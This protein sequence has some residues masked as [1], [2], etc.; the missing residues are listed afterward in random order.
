MKRTRDVCGPHV[1][2]NARI[3][4]VLMKNGTPEE[5][6]AEVRSLIDAGAP[7]ENFF[8][9]Y[10]GLDYGTPDEN[11][12]TALR[13][14]AEYGRIDPDVPEASGNRLFRGSRKVATPV[15]TS[16]S[17]ATKRWSLAHHFPLWS[18]ASASTPRAAKISRIV[19]G[20]EPRS[21]PF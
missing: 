21:G 5:I 7:L 3:S 6:A 10:R 4:P 13:T 16:V 12:R 11:V 19:G 1:A 2:V 14:A 15:E 20:G 8:H 18:L 9:R 17:S